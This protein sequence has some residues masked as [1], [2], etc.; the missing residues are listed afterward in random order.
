M[1][2]KFF[3]LFN[4]PM[5]ASPSLLKNSWNEFTNLLSTRWQTYLWYIILSALITVICLLVVGWAA[6]PTLQSF[7]SHIPEILNQTLDPAT[8]MMPN[9]SVFGIAGVVLLLSA[10]LL[11]FGFYRVVL[12]KKSEQTPGEILSQGT[13][14]YFWTLLVSIAAAI[15]VALVVGLGFILLILPGIYLAVGLAFTAFFVILDG[16]GPV[17]S[18]SASRALVKGRWWSVFGTLLFWGLAGFLATMVVSFIFNLIF[19]SA[20]DL[21]TVD[22]LAR[23][24]DQAMREAQM[25]GNFDQV[26][27]QISQL[28]AQ[29]TNPKVL[30]GFGLDFFLRALLMIVTTFGIFGTYL[31]LKKKK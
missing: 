20:L 8:L 3:N 10:V 30:I 29:F 1:K 22:S 25:S 14:K 9:F 19:A 26:V 7:M 16:K 2:W 11:R 23:S 31:A 21:T 13:E 6:Y 18:M 4:F 24:L 27:S 17:E 12:S 28:M 15:L 5:A